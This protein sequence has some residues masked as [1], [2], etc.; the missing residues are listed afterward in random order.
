MS[1]GVKVAV[2][3]R[4]YNAREKERN[5]E[6]VISMVSSKIENNK[7]IKHKQNIFHN[8]IIIILNLEWANYYY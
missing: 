4:P 7:N 5:A 2:R 1:G 6:L 3:V 8:I